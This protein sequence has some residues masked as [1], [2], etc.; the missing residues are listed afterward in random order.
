MGLGGASALLAKLSGKSGK[1]GSLAK[2][3]GSVPTTV[4]M[5]LKGELLEEQARLLLA[6]KAETFVRAHFLQEWGKPKYSL[7]SAVR[8]FLSHSMHREIPAHPLPVS[9]LVL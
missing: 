6:M 4:R 5:P 3:L 9:L 8:L 7:S 2:A 1:S